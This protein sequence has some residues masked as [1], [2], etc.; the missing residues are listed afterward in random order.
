MLFYL[1][2]VGEEKCPSTLA[3]RARELPLCNS[4]ILCHKILID[5]YINMYISI[6]IQN[7]KVYNPLNIA[8]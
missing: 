6:N 5:K 4:W 2:G 7:K 3:W 8:I 1:N